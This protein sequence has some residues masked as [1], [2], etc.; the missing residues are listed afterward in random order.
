MLK[1]NIKQYIEYIRLLRRQRGDFTD[2]DIH[3]YGREG[4]CI[5]H[6]RFGLIG[7]TG[8]ILTVRA[9]VFSLE[10]AGLHLTGYPGGLVVASYE[11]G[12]LTQSEITSLLS[13][14][15]L[16]HDR[17]ISRCGIGVR[18]E[19]TLGTVPGETVAIIRSLRIL[20][21]G[22]LRFVFTLMSFLTKGLLAGLD[23]TL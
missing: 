16:R 21:G 15:L 3:R 10:S 8:V 9:H 20:F 13:P 7:D 1:Q 23:D 14:P 18:R 12:H 6:R 5:L 11:T 19:R 22:C 4:S 2:S 17:E